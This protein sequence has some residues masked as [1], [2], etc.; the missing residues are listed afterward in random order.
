M[1][2]TIFTLGV[3]ET[4]PITGNGCGILNMA[5]VGG[6][7]LPLIQGIIAGHIGIHHA[8]FIPLICCVYILFYALNG[9]KPNSERH[10][11]IQA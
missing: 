11:Q 7:I 3:A 8:F 1:F 9:S 5:I 10:A 4:G 2:P 6:A